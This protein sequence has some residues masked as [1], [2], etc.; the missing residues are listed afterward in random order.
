MEITI[1]WWAVPTLLTVVF[2][3]W[4]VFSPAERGTDHFGTGAAMS[5]FGALALLVPLLFVWILYLALS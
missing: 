5:F 3:C 1:G 2:V 4:L